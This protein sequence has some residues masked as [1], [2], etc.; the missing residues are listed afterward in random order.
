MTPMYVMSRSLVS[1]HITAERTSLLSEQAG[2]SYG[3]DG[4]ACSVVGVAQ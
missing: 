2:V 4:K 1:D 3:T